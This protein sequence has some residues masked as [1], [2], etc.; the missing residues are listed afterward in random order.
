MHKVLLIPGTSICNAA[1]KFEIQE[2]TMRFGLKKAK[3]NEPLCK[4]GCK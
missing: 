3:T 2:S 4:S 1:K